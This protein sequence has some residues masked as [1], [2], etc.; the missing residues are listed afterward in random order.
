LPPFLALACWLGIFYGDNMAVTQKLLISYLQRPGL[1]R[2]ARVILYDLLEASLTGQAKKA[3]EYIRD[4]P[5]CTSMDVATALGK[6]ANHT[7]NILR[8]LL[9]W[10]LLRREPVGTKE[11]LHYRWWLG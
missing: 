10:G 6:P 4:N 1:E 3:Y 7:D 9:D 8:R 2:A 5:G 11:G